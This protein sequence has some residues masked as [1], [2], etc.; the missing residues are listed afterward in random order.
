[1]SAENGRDTITI[2]YRIRDAAGRLVAEHHRIEK[3]G[4]HKACFW[5]R[6]NGAWG[7]NGTPLAELPLYGSEQVSSWPEDDL[8]VLA[9]GEKARD[10]ID[11]TDFL[12]GVGTVCGASATP[13]S[14]AL[15]VLR[16]RRVCLWP[17]ADESGIAHMER[18][19]ERLHRIASEVLVFEW[20]GAPEK[21]DAA[22]HPAIRSRDRKDLDRLLSD[23]ESAPRWKPSALRLTRT[24]AEL[25]AREIPATR[26]AV[27][28]I[29]PEGVT[30]LAGKPKLGKSWLGLG[31]G[32][33]T[34]SGGYALGKKRVE[35]GEALYLA[36]EDN[37]RRLQ[38]RL[39]KL[40]DSGSDLSRLH[41][42]TE[43]PRLNEG[44]A[45]ELRAW[46][47][48][49][50]NTR[51]VVIDTLA[52]I[53]KPAHG[54]NV[55]RED[56]EALEKLLPLASEY[57]V[58][59]LVVHHLRKM[60]A[61]DPMDEISGSTGLSGGVDGFLIL[62]RDR[63]R[64][65]AT[66]H[67]DGR[68]VEEPAELALKWDAEL[69]AWT[70]VGDADEYRMTQDRAEIV[71]VL[72]AS[73]PKPMTPK[74]VAAALGKTPA[75]IGQ[76][77]YQ[78]RQA[79]Q[80]ISPDRG[81]YTVDKDGKDDK[82][83]KDDKGDKDGPSLSKSGGDKDGDKDESRMN[84]GD[85]RDL[86]DLIDFRGR[87]QNELTRRDGI[88]RGLSVEDAAAEMRRPNSGPRINLPLYLADETTLEILTKSVLVARGMDTDEAERAS[89]LA[90]VQ[91][92]ATDPANHPLDCACEG[93][94]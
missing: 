42:A 48:A 25:L 81:L 29:L 86:I 37:E 64:H 55:Y 19:A 18:I 28:G 57:G 50:P 11:R 75:N 88:R 51:L 69:A 40:T 44:G 16:G 93:C 92:A 36:L 1:M 12:C 15:E 52:K 66:L 43:W 89:C 38:K 82:D 83:N 53:R 17:D 24:A 3:P 27:P 35:P 6:P 2:V 5:K 60:A 14:E 79:G 22:D 67:V 73:W 39:K 77:L 10:A 71:E 33:A 59:V 32:V 31:L 74:E 78:M 76:R 26:W 90:V 34:A 54:Q 45:D 7:L 87:G 80:V 94:L 49:H 72:R 70:L 58:A 68:D 63:G 23:L 47:N 65:D 56:Y 20:S 21:G 13:G 9:E 41:Y 62:K 4:G 84:K 61:S 91:E 46:L 30:L 8:I 85:S